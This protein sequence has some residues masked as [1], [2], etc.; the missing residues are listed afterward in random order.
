M[1]NVIC[2]TESSVEAAETGETS[3]NFILRG[4]D[5]N[6]LNIFTVISHTH[7]FHN[8]YIHISLSTHTSGGIAKPVAFYRFVPIV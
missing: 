2:E 3:R 8:F 5:K 7:L 1:L 4:R 6:P